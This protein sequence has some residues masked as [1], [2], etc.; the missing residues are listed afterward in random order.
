MS[1]RKLKFRICEYR[2]FL[3]LGSLV[4]LNTRFLYLFSGLLNE[5]EHLT[6]WDAKDLSFVLK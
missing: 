1:L 6:D 3:F 4:E 5:V 2:H